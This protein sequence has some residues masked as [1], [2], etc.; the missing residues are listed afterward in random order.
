[1]EEGGWRQQKR[2]VN[3]EELVELEVL[4]RDYGMEGQA[5]GVADGRRRKGDECG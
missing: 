4:C 2:S 3:R 1:M 5:L